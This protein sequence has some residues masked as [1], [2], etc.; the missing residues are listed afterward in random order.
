MLPEGQSNLLLES[1]LTAMG[2]GS[3]VVSQ[4]FQRLLITREKNKLLVLRRENQQ[5]CTRSMRG[6]TVNTNTAGGRWY[7]VLCS[8][9]AQI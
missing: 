5:C 1:Y 6:S 9:T 7:G 2:A 4:A 3:I 8:D